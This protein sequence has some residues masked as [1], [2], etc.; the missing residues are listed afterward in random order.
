MVEEIQPKVEEMNVLSND[1][2][3]NIKFVLKIRE[4]DPE[5][6]H[7]VISHF[8]FGNEIII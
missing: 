8:Y 6:L 5:N 3:R 2:K 7:T 1:L 4:D